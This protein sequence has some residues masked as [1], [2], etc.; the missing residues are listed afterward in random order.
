MTAVAA[1][2]SGQAPSRQGPSAITVAAYIAGAA[3][4]A[5][6][7]ALLAGFYSLR[8]AA[9]TW[10]PKEVEFDE[11][12]SVMLT[13]TL[14][15]SGAV[16]GWA[17]AATRAGNRRQALGA[18]ILAIGLGGAFLNLAWYTGAHASFGPS[19]HAFGAIVISALALGSAAVVV[20]L[21]FLALA[22]LRAQLRPEG[23][24][25]VVAAARFWFLVIA[26]WLATPVALYGLMSP[27]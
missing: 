16:V 9:A 13:A 22:L 10:P 6:S 15:L 4:F 27:K 18:L 23:G 5:A 17:S 8:D 20:G 2:E 19:S 26:A 11:Y 3:V 21:G 14:L 7:L 24:E 1:L 12:F 25:A